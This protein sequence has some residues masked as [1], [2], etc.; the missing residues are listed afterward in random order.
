MLVIAQGCLVLNP[1]ADYS[2]AGGTTDTTA[3]STTDA[4]STTAATS[5]TDATASSA[6]TDTLGTTA[7][8][9]TGTTAESTST[10]GCPLEELYVDADGDG[11]GVGDPVMVCAGTPGH[12]MTPGD[13]DDAAKGINPGATEICDPMKIDEDCDG[14][15]NEASPMNASCDGCLLAEYGGHAY[16]SCPADTWDAG[17]TTCMTFGADLTMIA[18]DGENAFVF[19]LNQGITLWLG[20]RDSG[21]LIYLWHDGSALNYDYWVGPNPD[22][23]GGCIAMPNDDGGGWRDRTC[24]TAYGIICESP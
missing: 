9:T 17:R 15:A 22:E 19:S 8:A 23:P 21:G 4:A 16:W 24:A 2:T 14:L 7:A 1:A 10:T 3:T 18:D 5:T 13:C 12:A 11:Y 6:G 20:G